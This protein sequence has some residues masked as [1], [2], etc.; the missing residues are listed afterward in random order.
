M[1]IEHSDFHDQF[2]RGLTHKMNNILSL[3]HGYL[4][5]L[6]DDKSLDAETQDGLRRIKD[7]AHTA[8]ELMDRTKALARPASLVWREIDVKK[9]L[10][11][12]TPA[13]ED[14]LEHGASLEIECAE[15]MPSIFGDSARLKIALIE[16]VH[17][18]CEASPA[19]GVIA[20]NVHSESTKF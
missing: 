4:G 7:G 10:R 13:F 11:L 9:F 19:K 18:A 15:N 14:F 6:M 8:S 3:F 2:V 17:N 20:V 5:L 12:L 16:L 1:H